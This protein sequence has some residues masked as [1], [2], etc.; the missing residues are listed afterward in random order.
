MDEL[1]KI[2]DE[3]ATATVKGALWI[4]NGY[5]KKMSSPNSP[6]PRNN[7]TTTVDMEDEDDTS[8]TMG[9]DTI[10]NRSIIQHEAKGYFLKRRI[11]SIIRSAYSATTGGRT[12]FFPIKERTDHYAAEEAKTLALYRAMHP[13]ITFTKCGEDLEKWKVGSFGMF[14]NFVDPVPILKKLGESN[15]ID[16]DANYYEA[17][18]TWQYRNL[19][20][21]GTWSKWY[22]AEKTFQEDQDNGGDG[23]K[24]WET[25]PF[26]FDF[27]KN[28]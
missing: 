17:T 15:A 7:L 3:K 1:A 19:L 8:S 14:S 2:E 9:W 10:S 18:T 22:D 24:S 11:A 16:S 4:S 28:N 5:S 26:D 25:H 20:S 23:I 27:C 21:N 6:P 12:M 13:T